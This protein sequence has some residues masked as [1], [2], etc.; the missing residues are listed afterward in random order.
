MSG[1]AKVALANFCRIIQGGRLGLS[2][3]DFV[4]AGG[5]PAYGAGGLNGRLPVAEFNEPAVILSAI[6]ARCGKCFHANGEWTSLANTQ[7]IFP[8][9]ERAD[10]RFL[11]HQLNNEGRWHRSGTGQPF[12]KP[13]DVKSHL[14]VLPPLCAQRRIADILDRAD[15]M[16]AARRTAIAAAES[17]TP[18]LFM[19]LFGEPRSNP[20]AWPVVELGTL[21]SAGP[22][23]GLYKPSGDYGSGT[24]ILRIDGFYDGVVTGVTELKRVRLTDAERATYGLAEGDVVV[25]R[26]NSRQYLGKSALIPILPEP[27]VFESNMMRLSMNRQMAE[28]TYV[29]QF[30]QTSFAKSQI[31]GAAKDAINQSSI[32]QQDLKAIRL[33]LPPL[34]LQRQFTRRRRAVE[35]MLAAHRASLVET[36]AL[37][38]SLQHRAFRGEL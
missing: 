31:L 34:D 1:S 24:L 8:D 14:V 38:A 29:V 23:N 10:S 5:Y 28:P 13:S 32:N 17:M 25:N 9:P 37:F 12:I 35:K 22:Q 16:R 4:P 18:A 7:L 21:I 19:N 15:A 2:G 6:G 26:V 27:V 36:D 30:L 20:N 33:P 11:W 3:Y